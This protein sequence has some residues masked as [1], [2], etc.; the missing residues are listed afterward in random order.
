MDNADRRIV[1][2]VGFAKLVTGTV[3]V[4]VDPRGAKGVLL[5][6]VGKKDGTSKS[7]LVPGA[8]TDRGDIGSGPTCPGTDVKVRWRAKAVRMVLA[9]KCLH[10]GNY[11][12]IPFAVLTENGA[13]A[14]SDYA[15]QTR[16]GHLG[17][18]RWLP[19]G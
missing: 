15:P 10:H 11:G 13:G 6:A 4:S 2:R 7:Y 9:S 14:D 3:L 18:S 12:A 19:R 8:F 17:S 5:I 1:M 16:R